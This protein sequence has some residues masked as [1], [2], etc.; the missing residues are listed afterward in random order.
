MWKL[1]NNDG[2]LAAY[3][4]SKKSFNLVETPNF[5]VG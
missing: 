2:E 4:I 3:K 1:Q 5:Y